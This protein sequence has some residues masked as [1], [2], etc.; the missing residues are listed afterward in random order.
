VSPWF[1][2][3]V[4]GVAPTITGTRSFLRN[5]LNQG[6]GAR[7]EGVGAAPTPIYRLLFARSHAMASSKTFPLPR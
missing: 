4:L 7:L 1:K 5:G 3:L 6:L 2:E